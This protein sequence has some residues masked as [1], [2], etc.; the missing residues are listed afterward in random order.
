V[1]PVQNQTQTAKASALLDSVIDAIESPRISPGLLTPQSPMQS[2]DQDIPE[3][4]GVSESLDSPTGRYRNLA[5]AIFG[6]EDPVDGPTATVLR[7][8][9]TSPLGVSRSVSNEGTMTSNAST[10][11][12][13]RTPEISGARLFMGQLSSP[14]LTVPDDDE[15]AKQVLAKVEAATMALRKS[16]SNPKF[17]DGLGPPI[18]PATKRKVD[19]PSQIG[20]GAACRKSPSTPATNTTR[21]TSRICLVNDCRVAPSPARNIL[22]PRTMKARSSTPEIDVFEATVYGRRGA[23]SPS[24]Q[25]APFS[26]DYE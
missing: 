2:Q 15:L 24:G 22:D 20:P 21:G 6:P 14:K 4:P 5:D 25:L 11:H 3:S 18:P 8:H 26:T 7:I 19:R 9:T 16:P 12:L 13:P 1:Q 23:V 17:P 10:S